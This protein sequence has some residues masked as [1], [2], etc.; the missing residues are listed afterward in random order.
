MEPVSKLERNRLLGLAGFSGDGFFSGD[1]LE[2]LVE[3]LGNSE[4]DTANPALV[5]DVALSTAD[6]LGHN[7]YT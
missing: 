2:E 5:K 4:S 3:G 7:T 1:G 6:I